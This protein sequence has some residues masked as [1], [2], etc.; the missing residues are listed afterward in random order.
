MQNDIKLTNSAT[1]QRFPA[2]FSPSGATSKYFFSTLLASSLN[3]FLDFFASCL[4]LVLLTNDA[5]VLDIYGVFRSAL[6][7]P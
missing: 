1:A 6:F 2:A 7:L 4:H 5:T 3:I